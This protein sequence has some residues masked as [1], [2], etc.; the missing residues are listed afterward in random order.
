MPIAHLVEIEKNNALS[1]EGVYYFRGKMNLSNGEQE[2]FED[3]VQFTGS[4]V[5]LFGNDLPLT[6]EEFTGDW[7]F[8]D[9]DPADLR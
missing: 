9:L 2:D 4:S 8:L 7:Y 1:R 3:W 6:V 5:W